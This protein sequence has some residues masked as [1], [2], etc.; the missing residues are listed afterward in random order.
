MK[1]EIIDRQCLVCGKL[2]D[3]YHVITEC[4]LFANWRSMFLPKWLYNKPSMYKLISYLDSIKY[5]DA[6]KLGIFCHKVFDYILKNIVW[7]R[8]NSWQ[9]FFCEYISFVTFP[10]FTL[11]KYSFFVL[12]LFA[13]VHIERIWNRSCIL[14]ISFFSTDTSS[15]WCYFMVEMIC[16]F[17][18]L[19]KAYK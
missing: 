18:E 2:D 3:E 9:F 8:G 16:N 15:M 6:R 14:F 19:A 4:K 5:D 10:E 7:S 12:Y 13:S 17:W 1:L 11:L